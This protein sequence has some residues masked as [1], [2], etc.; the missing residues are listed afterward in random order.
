MS[1]QSAK[2]FLKRIETDQLE[3]AAD[4]E[5]RRQIIKEAGFD[6]TV[7]EF[8]QAVAELAAAA[9]KELTPEELQEIAGGTAR[10]S[11]CTSHHCS[12]VL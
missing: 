4:L 12:I 11:W 8:K 3:A 9:G 6:F 1:A 5:A 7:D 10:I 2:D